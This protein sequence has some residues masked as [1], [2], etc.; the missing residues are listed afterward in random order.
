MSAM[1]PALPRRARLFAAV[2]SCVA[3]ASVVAQFYYLNDLRGQ[4]YAETAWDMARFFT[5]L[6]NL[7]IAWTWTR[8]AL[9]REG[10][11]PPWVAS[12]TLASLI[13]GAV[14]HLLLAHLIDFEGIGW[15]ADH[16]LHAVVP[17]ACLAWWIA[18][19]PKRRLVY[20][21]LPIFVLWP[22]IYMAYVLARGSVEGRYPYPFMDLTD[23]SQA[24]VAT[25]LAG[26][27]LVLLIG[28]VIFIMIGRYADR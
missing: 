20:A 11:H 3:V 13:V 24:A 16:G 18:F 2:I 28:G 15:F 21:D 4:T 12:L 26:L 25:N 9:R 23:L 10:I 5:I 1:F 19:A 14:Y 27:T 17:L 7:L 22:S 6:T 8:A